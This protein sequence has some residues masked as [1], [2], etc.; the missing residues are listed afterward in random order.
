M[1]SGGNKQT[2]TRPHLAVVNVEGALGSE[3]SRFGRGVVRIVGANRLV[4]RAAFARAVLLL[5]RRLLGGLHVL[6]SRRG[7][8]DLL[9]LFD[10]FRRGRGA[11]RLGQDEGARDDQR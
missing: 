8:L 11:R 7:L 6:R 3:R 10:R 4:R 1:R 2:L 9:G 5:L